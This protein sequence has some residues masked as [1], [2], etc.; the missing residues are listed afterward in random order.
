MTKSTVLTQIL[1]RK[2]SFACRL[3][4]RSDDPAFP[5]LTAQTIAAD[6]D[7][8]RREIL[9]SRTRSR[10]RPSGRTKFSDRLASISIVGV[11]LL[12][13][14]VLT[15]IAWPGDPAKA[16]STV[17]KMN[18]T[19]E[20]DKADE[21]KLLVL[22]LP[23]M[24]SPE[25]RPLLFRNIETATTYALGSGPG[26]T[27]AIR[28]VAECSASAL[29]LALPEDFDLERTPRLAWRWRVEKGLEVDGEMTQ[30]GDD[31]A[32][33]IYVLFRF[34]PK[35][36][37]LWKRMRNDLGQRVFDAEIPGEALNY[38]WASRISAGEH[39]TSPTQEDAR[40]IVLETRSD[41]PG[42]NVWREAVVDLAAD[43]AR[44][45]D[46]PPR[47]SPYAI[48][49]MTDSDDS[50]QTAIAGYSDFRLLGPKAPSDSS[51]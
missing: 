42:S 34:D 43:A 45:F 7:R 30:E 16:D 28:A 11:L 44:V 47:L 10:L 13:F 24:G 6:S 36:A 12:V 29:L 1:A 3:W 14:A 23:A 37:S 46:P 25:W 22:P 9:D 17:A 26:N 38:V 39:W 31:F 19:A 50:C 49:L 48:G 18:Q 40:L 4:A 33:R 8:D 51:Q 41:A 21:G 35:R 15:T 27:P 32:A 5:I 20:R 2:A